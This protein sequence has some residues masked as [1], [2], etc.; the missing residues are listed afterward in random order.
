MSQRPATAV[1]MRQALDHRLRNEAAKRGTT[2]ER[3]RT[4]LMMERLLARLFHTEDAPWLLKGGLA[5]EL[6]YH[7]RARSTRDV[8]LAMLANDSEST[9][10]PSTLAVARD[11]LQRAAQLDLGDY[12]RFTI[13]E[14]RKELHGPPQGGASFPVTARLADKEF[15]RFHVDVGLGDALVGA[16][17]LLVGDDLLGFAGI[18]P[19]RV[20]AISRSQQFAE[21]L[22][23]YTY[24]WG[25]RE[26]KRVKDL[27]DMVL[28]IERGALDAQQVHEAARATF[29]VRARHNLPK[30]LAPPPAAWRDEYA[31]LAAEAEVVA[32]DVDTAF[33]LLAGYWSSV[34]E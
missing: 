1:A 21:K 19:A 18:G 3:L 17:E 27:V 23:A 29:A 16:P 14:A 22:H 9:R 7:P 6:R 25:D 28:L 34:V 5:F 15:G 10:E 26:N 30:Q 4:K 11:A 31:A 20:R 33:Q 13:G 8:D 2:F 12:L 32:R 24:P